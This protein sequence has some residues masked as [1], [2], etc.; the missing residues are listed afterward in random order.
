LVKGTELVII[1]V[2]QSVVIDHPLSRELLTNDINNIS[3][4]FIRN[5][6]IKINPAKILEKILKS[7]EDD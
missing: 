3:N 4:Y 7:R 6:N 5:Y 1:D 2:G